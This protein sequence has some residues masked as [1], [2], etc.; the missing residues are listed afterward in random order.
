MTEYEKLLAEQ[1]YNYS[2]SELYKMFMRAYMLTSRI[3]STTFQDAAELKRLQRELIPDMDPTATIIPPFRCDMGH[4]IKLGKNTF[5]NYNCSFLDN[6][7]IEI[8]DN[9]LIGP[10]CHI[11][12]SQHPIDYMERR[13]PVENSYR[14]RLGNDCWLGANVTVCPGV[15]IGDRVIVA[16]GSV[17]I[18]DVPSDMMVAGNP[19]VIKK[20]LKVK[21]SLSV[22]TKDSLSDID[23]I[24]NCF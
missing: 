3:N 20:W 9:T 11:L 7:G 15:T 10:D 6:G 12:T 18:R 4:R 21:D 23:D 24:N 2:D 1:R 5:V 19:A 16:A 8:G 13:Q 14:I 22:K 17:V